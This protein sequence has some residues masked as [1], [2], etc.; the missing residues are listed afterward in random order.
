[1]FIYADD[2]IIFKPDGDIF[3]DIP[4]TGAWDGAWT[5]VGL[6]VGVVTPKYEF[7][8]NSSNI[9]AGISKSSYVFEHHIDADNSGNQGGLFDTNLDVL[10]YVEGTI[11]GTL[12]T[13]YH[14]VHG[15]I[16]Y[17]IDNRTFGGSEDG[18]SFS[19][20]IHGVITVKKGI[21]IDAS[22]RLH[23]R[24]VEGTASGNLGTTGNTVKAAGYFA[25]SGTADTNYGVFSS[26]S[27]ATANWAGMFVGSH[28]GICDGTCGTPGQATGAGDL[29][30]EDDIE[31]DGSIY[32]PAGQK[33]C[34]GASGD[35]AC[36]FY[37]TT[38]NTFNITDW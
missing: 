15:I 13:D 28:V 26:A 33:I 19:K 14:D 29:Y 11:D 21:S 32:I 4:N 1:M 17:M 30:V 37:D 12:D 24:A 35:G 23:Q 10:T 3:F 9:L 5:S 2:D 20:A 34:F 36:L 31:T 22:S 8:A 7:H 6:G 25:S 27:G 38:A 18:D 16:S